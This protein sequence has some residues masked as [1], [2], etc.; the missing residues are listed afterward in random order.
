MPYTIAIPSYNRPIIL[1]YKTLN[2]LERNSIDPK[3]IYIFIVEEDLD[4]YSQI[5]TYLYNKMVIGVKGIVKQREFIDNYFKEGDHIV[6]IDDDIQDLIFA[7]PHEEIPLDEFLNNAFELCKKE[8][9]FLWGLYPVGNAFY[10]Q[11][12]KWYS[13]HLTY[14]IGAFYGYINRPTN[15]EIKCPLT[16]NG[17]NA[18]DYE[19][20]IRYWLH[21]KKV[22]RFNTVCIKTKYFNCVGGI[23][24]FKDRLESMEFHCKLLHAHYPSYTRVYVKKNG[25]YNLRLKDGSG[26]TLR[27]KTQ[28]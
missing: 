22:I 21:D 4:D 1:L 14:I 27:H 26:Q 19:R 24:N 13:T 16:Y 5:P 9:A 28:N 3:L 7:N 12:N 10:A 2:F 11:K 8:E 25:M 18:E 15:E 23:G 20:S 6:S 17:Q